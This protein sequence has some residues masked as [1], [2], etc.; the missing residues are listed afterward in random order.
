MVWPDY[1]EEARLAGIKGD[2]WVKVLVQ[3]DGKVKK[4]VIIKSDSEIFDQPAIAAALQWEFT[5]AI[6][7][8]VPVACWQPLLFRFPKS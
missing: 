6:M 2:V 8:K 1:P 4:A 3:T 5:P 7:N